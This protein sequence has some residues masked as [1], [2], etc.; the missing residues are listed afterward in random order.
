MREFGEAKQL[1][2]CLN[3]LIDEDAADFVTGIT[4]PVDGGFLAGSGV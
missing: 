3:W 4:I 2:G 1:L